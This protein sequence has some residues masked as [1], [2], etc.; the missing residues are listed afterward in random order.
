MQDKLYDPAGALDHL[1]A[2]DP[3]IADAVKIWTARRPLAS[4]EFTHVIWSIIG[5]QISVPP[6][7]ALASYAGPE[8]PKPDII[9]NMP[10][11]QVMQ[12]GL[13]RRK[14]EYLIGIAR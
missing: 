14:A 11:E 1:A 6:L 3:D 5:Q 10:V 9:A 4:G 7:E 13:S 12:A 8:Y 2:L